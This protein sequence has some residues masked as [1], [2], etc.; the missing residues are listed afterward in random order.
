MCHIIGGEQKGSKFHSFSIMN[1]PVRY[2]PLVNYLLG[3]DAS[4]SSHARPCSQIKSCW[5]T[6]EECKLIWDLGCLMPLI[7][8][9]LRVLIGILKTRQHIQVLIILTTWLIWTWNIPTWFWSV[10]YGIQL[11]DININMIHGTFASYWLLWKYVRVQYSCS[12]YLAG[13]TIFLQV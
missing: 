7:I 1:G 10:H 6:T 13:R 4:V 12:V 11:S 5:C 9:I 2:Q 8:W 3:S